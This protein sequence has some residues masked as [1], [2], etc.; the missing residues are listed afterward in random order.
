MIQQV[1]RG[2]RVSVKTQYE[3][4]FIKNSTPN[5]A[6]RYL[7]TIE[8][9]S[10]EVVQLVR[11]HWKITESNKSV[12]VVD[13][14]GIVGKKPIIKSGQIIQYKSGCIIKSSSGAMKGYYTLT[15][16]YT[17]LTLPTKA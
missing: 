5:H 12:Q 14:P 11:R 7:I 13:G 16:S 6:F 3:G 2:I 4:S 17:H 9:Q 10:N 15:V 1:T 8:N